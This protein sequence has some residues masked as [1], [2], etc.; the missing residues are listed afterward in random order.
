MNKHLIE[1]DGAEGGGQILRSALSLSMITG[2]ALRIVNI[3]GR[4]SRPGLLRQH[5]TAVRAAAEIC[6]AAVEGDELGSRSLTFRPAAIRGGDYRFAIGSA[7]SAV[8]VLQTLLPALLFADGPSNL[9][10]SGGTHNPLAPPAD[11][12]A[13]SWLPL[14]RRMGAKVDFELLRHGFMPA[15]GGELRARVEPG[16]LRPLHLPEAGAVRSRSARAL[17]AAIP[18]HVADRELEKV[19][20]HQDWHTAA[21]Q[22]VRLPEEQGPGNALLLE[23]ECEHLTLMFCAFG[24]PG[25]SAERV[26]SQALRQADDWRSSAA[27]VEEHLADQLLLPLA[28]AGGGSFTTPQ[29]SEHLLSNRA[30]IEAFLPVRIA[31]EP[32]VAGGQHIRITP[33]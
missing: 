13:R 9:A 14:L 17:L 26:A 30:V 6:G 15:G 8:L 22:V 31:C 23:V 33:A 19:R 29:P 24:Q 16:E 5:L 4:R 12:I 21:A 3:R 11:F 2:K 20:R 7:G 10:I 28:L 25:V 32:R 1:L 27:S 18:G